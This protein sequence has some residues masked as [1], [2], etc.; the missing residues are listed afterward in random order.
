MYR[1]SSLKACLLSFCQPT[2]WLA[3]GAT[4][5]AP[6]QAATVYFQAASTAAQAVPL[7]PWVA[8]LLLSAM[9][10][11][12][13][14]RAA[15]S[16]KRHA[17]ASVCGLCALA[18]AGLLVV[19]PGR[20]TSTQLMVEPDN[21]AC[22]GGAG[23]LDFDPYTDGITLHNGCASTPLEVTGHDLE[24][25]DIA[26][27]EG[28]LPDGARLQPGE[29]LAVS[30]CDVDVN[31]PPIFIVA[32]G[33]ISVAEDAGPQSFPGLVGGV[34]PGPVHEAAQT[35]S[36][37]VSS[38][39]PALFSAGPA[40][41][42]DGEL[43]FTTAPDAFGNS[44][45][46]IVATDSDGASS[47]RTLRLQV[48]PVNDPPTFNLLPVVTVLEDGGLDTDTANVAFSDTRVS[49]PGVATAIS[50]GNAWEADAGE[51][52]RFAVRFVS[53]SY[54]RYGN[55]PGI[56]TTTWYN[57]DSGYFAIPAGGS[58]A[59]AVQL[60]ADGALDL[61]LGADRWGQIRLE[62]TAI[63]EHGLASAPQ[64]LSLNIEPV[65]DASP[66]GEEKLIYLR[67]NSACIQTFI[68]GTTFRGITM[69]HFLLTDRDLNG[70]RLAHQDLATRVWSDV[71]S[72]GVTRLQS[73]V[74]CYSPPTDEHSIYDPVSGEF[75]IFA[76]FKYRVWSGEGDMTTGESEPLGSSGQFLELSP[77]YEV[78]II[79]TP[80]Y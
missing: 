40:L 46:R 62:V 52:L 14:G 57:E 74:I 75:S 26:R 24:C 51:T 69:P 64:M 21:A 25:A 5:V 45:L 6:A 27:R 39:Q 41:A 56:P 35:V 15:R 38:D 30:H 28:E 37:A 79:V 10:I 17:V 9:L 47:Q 55:L 78:S 3:V 2:L 58:I 31:E 34:S 66:V 23:Q 43:T 36:L 18:F 80:G 22:L 65:F 76:S 29:A 71:P 72:G 42:P 7:W 13:G 73:R 59:D 63:D 50:P 32:S 20:A 54:Q 67:E 77:E 4:A 70:G 49:V 16:A 1:K 61:V 48:T 8:I 44:E 53:G 33:A 68:R 11:G 12:F 19:Q 60:R